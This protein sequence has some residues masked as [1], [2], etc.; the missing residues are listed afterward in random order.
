MK[1]LKGSGVEMLL[2]YVKDMP[3]V[4]TKPKFDLSSLLGALF[5]TWI[6]ELLFPVSMRCNLS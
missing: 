2:E 6:I 3:K 1:F 4:G 5:F